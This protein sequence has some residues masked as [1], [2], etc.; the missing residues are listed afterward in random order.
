MCIMHD[1]SFFPNRNPIFAKGR[2]RW[3]RERAHGL[4]AYLLIY[5]LEIFILNMN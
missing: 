2:R 1:T 4:E 5:G 3:V